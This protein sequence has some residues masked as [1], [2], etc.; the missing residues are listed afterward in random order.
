VF[1]HGARAWSDAFVGCCCCDGW[2]DA[3]GGCVAPMLVLVFV[4]SGGVDGSK[5]SGVEAAVETGFV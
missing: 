2:V 3:E 5:E 1:C 4:W